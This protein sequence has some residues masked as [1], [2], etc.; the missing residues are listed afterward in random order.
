[1][2]LFQLILLLKLPKIALPSPFKIATRQ[3]SSAAEFTR[4]ATISK[5]TL[6]NFC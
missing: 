3:R 6:Y 1:M 4:I 2:L 5:R